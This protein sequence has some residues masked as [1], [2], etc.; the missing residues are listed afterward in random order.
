MKYRCLTEDELKELETEF[1]HFLISNQ[2]YTEEWES[3]NKSKD[4][5]VAQLIEMFSDIV[6]DK[7]LKNIKYIEHVSKISFNAFYC[8]EDEMDLIGISS[9]KQ[10]VDF[11]NAKL[12]DIKDEL[13]IFKTTKLYYKSRE[14]E[15]FDLLNSGCS[16][17]DAEKYK[18]IELAYTYS[19]KQNKN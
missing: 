5:K 1:K 15:I 17:I 13:N 10:N 19:C 14:E 2:V 11:N 6:I 7:A 3:L 8:K 16:I 12:D 9:D 4:K 18:K